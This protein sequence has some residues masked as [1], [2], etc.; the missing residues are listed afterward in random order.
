MPSFVAKK[1]IDLTPAAIGPFVIAV[2]NLDD[3]LR[4]PTSSMVSCGGQAT[5]TIVAAF[6]HVAPLL[7]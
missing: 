7:S 6:L 4:D 3:S 5:I 2:V 1:V